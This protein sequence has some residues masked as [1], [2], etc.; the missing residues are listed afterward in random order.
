MGQFF[1]VQDE[2]PRQRAR[3]LRQAVNLFDAISGLRPCA[4]ERFNGAE[5]AL[6]P[7][8]AGKA[9]WAVQQG[10]S[11]WM[12]AVGACFYEGRHGQAAL[13]Q[14]DARLAAGAGWEAALKGVDGCFAMVVAKAHSPEVAV[15]TDRLGSLHVY[16]ARIGSATVASSSALIL[17]ALMQARWDLTACREF[18]ATGTVFENRSLFAGVEKLPPASVLELG[19]GGS[20]RA[21]RYW[22]LRAAMYDW[23]PRHGTVPELAAALRQAVETI[24]RAYG[25]VVFDLTGGFDSRAVVGAAL[26]TGAAPQTV[27]VGGEGD[28]DV[29]AAGRIARTFQLPHLR[30]QLPEDW[31]RRWWRRAQQ[32]LALCDGECSVVEYGRILEHHDRLAR[33]FEAS[34]NGSGGELAKGYWWELLFPFTGWKGHF[35]ERRVA[36]ARFALRPH[37]ADILEGDGQPDL[38]AHFADVIRRANAGF[39]RHP[40]TAKMDN[41]YLTLRMQRWQGRIASATMRLWPCVSPF[42]MREPMELALSAPPAVR[43]R[44]RMSRRLIEHFNPQ[45]AALPLAQGYPALPLRWNTAVHFWPLAAELAAKVGARLWRRPG[46]G[47]H[48]A[49][50]QRWIESE[51]ARDLL[52]PEAMVS[53]PL[54][55]RRRLAAALERAAAGG[56]AE[57]LLMER[58]LTLEMVARAMQGVAA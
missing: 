18:L 46:Q 42:L 13:A 22:D 24:R 49:P 19:A 1:L 55:A 21:T 15:V 50:T 35:D 33:R 5:M 34:V 11:G 30:Q 6:F 37:D 32:A 45:L 14:L 17:G 44:H 53:G 41:V 8:L 58:V 26:Q 39:E 54:Y 10:A 25:E 23:A 36:A 9:T 28:P 51:P 27:V 3:L 47:N 20:G 12:A 2:D 4:L 29:E 43:V 16:A 40:N 48:K 31:N 7:A 38:V 57:S 52:R 56:A